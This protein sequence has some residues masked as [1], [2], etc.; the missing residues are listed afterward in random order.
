MIYLSVFSFHLCVC[1]CVSRSGNSSRE[2]A[3]Q[4]RKPHSHVLFLP[5]PPSETL[6]SGARAHTH[7]HASTPHTRA[8][9]RVHSTASPQHTRTRCRCGPAQGIRPLGPAAR[10]LPAPRRLLSR[11]A[12][13]ARWQRRRLP[14]PGTG[15]QVPARPKVRRGPDRRCGG[16]G[17]W[18][19]RSGAYR[20]SWRSLPSQRPQPHLT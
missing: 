1:V 2:R 16:T 15:A 3:T 18:V 14:S 8:A 10:P 12:V 17:G 5:S 13:L 4:R 11:T 20:G 9:R 19:G 7:T 6:S